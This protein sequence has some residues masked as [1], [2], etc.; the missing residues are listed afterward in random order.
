VSVPQ[1]LLEGDEPGFDGM[2]GL[3]EKFSL[4]PTPPLD[5]FDEARSPLPESYGTGKLFLT[6]RDPHWLYAHWDLTREEQFRHNA[7]SMDRHLVLRVHNGEPA[8]RPIAEY[9]V[10]PES[11]YWFVHV[12]RAGAT[13]TTE[14]GYYQS[15]RRWK[16]LRFSASQRTPSDNISADATAKFATIPADLSFATMLALLKETAGETV[17][18]STPL[19]H[20]VD[21]IRPRAPEHFPKATTTGDWTPEQEQALAAVI[22]AARAGQISSGEFATE[23]I[24]PEFAF[25]LETSAAGLGLS[26]S[27][28]ASSFFGG[29]VL[30]SFGSSLDLAK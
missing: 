24:G 2:A 1:F 30:S 12:D 10:H 22:A 16:S 3:A 21:K 29:G 20:A 8:V 26:L 5:H 27:S 4:G 13:Y 23:K 28:Y 25:D 17:V 14:L 18:Q 11:K 7:R 15:G 9:H 6:A 19:A